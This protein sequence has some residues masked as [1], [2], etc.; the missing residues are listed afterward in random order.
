MDHSIICSKKELL[1][2]QYEKI[3]YPTLD[4][5]DSLNI[6]ENNSND[7]IL[8]TDIDNKDFLNNF[9]DS[10]NLGYQKDKNKNYKKQEKE[11]FLETNNI[12]SNELNKTNEVELKRQLKLKRNREAAK[13]VRLRKKEFF[14]NLMIEYNILKNENKNLLNIINKCSKCKEKFRSISSDKRQKNNDKIND[15]LNKILSEENKRNFNKKKI[16][17]IT[18]VTIISIINIINIPLNIMN[19]FKFIENN[20]IEY[21]KIILLM[22]VKIYYLISWILQMIMKHYI[23]TL[24]NIII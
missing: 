10:F 3:D 8:L 17:F 14:E 5:N 9:F 23:F 22:K 6:R 18:A 16:F 15:S 11:S 4:I 20:K 1:N 13:E 21:I 2:I 19:C 24:L 12:I 7:N